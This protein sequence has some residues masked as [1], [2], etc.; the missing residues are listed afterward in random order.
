MCMATRFGFWN[1][2]GDTTDPLARFDK[3]SSVRPPYVSAANRK[4]AR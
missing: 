3:Y 1:T 2:P 4:A